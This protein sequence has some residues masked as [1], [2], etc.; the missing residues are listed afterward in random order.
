MHCSL[1]AIKYTLQRHRNRDPLHRGTECIGAF[2][3][4]QGFFSLSEIL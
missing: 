3:D 2:E 4:P 1:L